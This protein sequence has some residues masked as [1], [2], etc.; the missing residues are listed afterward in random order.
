M[1]MENWVLVDYENV[2]NINLELVAG[3]PVH[4][5]LFIGQQQ[6]S[7]PT[8]ILTM[9]LSMKE[10]VTVVKSSGMG[11]NAMDFQMAFHAGRIV[12]KNPH[13]FIHFVTK[14]KGFSVLE[15][16]MKEQKIRV[17][18]VG[19]FAALKFLLPKPEFKLLPPAERASHVVE[20]LN[21]Q[22]P[23]SRPRKKRTLLSSI[24]AIFGKKL[25]QGEV[26]RVVKELIAHGVLTIGQNE[27]VI[28]K[29]P[30]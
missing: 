10:Q 3:K 13:A 23:A 30:K 12:E 6:K 7:V 8:E 15:N 14:D 19:S 9:A 24:A 29:T 20:R 16:H 17:E 1:T 2:H 25:K 27:E 11:K 21:K 18:L 5:L 4:V 26:E 28:Y 22:T